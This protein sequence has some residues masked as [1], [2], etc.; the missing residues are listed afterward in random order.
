M[1]QMSPLLAL[2][3]RPLPPEWSQAVN[4]G[5]A[6]T[7]PIFPGHLSA[8]STVPSTRLINNLCVYEKV[9]VDLSSGG[10]RRS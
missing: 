5:S 7:R 2:K 10:A 1:A 4:S 9:S 6:E 8:A 3:D